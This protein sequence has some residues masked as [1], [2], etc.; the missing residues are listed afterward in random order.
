MI[1]IPSGGESPG[2]LELMKTSVHIAKSYADQELHVHQ[3]SS[4]RE[5][6][7]MFSANYG[8]AK[9]KAKNADALRQ[10]MPVLDEGDLPEIKRLLMLLDDQAEMFC[11][12]L[13]C[14][15][16]DLIPVQRQIYFDKSMNGIAENGVTETIG[17]LRTRHVFTSKEGKI[18]DGHHGWLSGMIIH[19]FEVQMLQFR[20][21]K[22]LAEVLPF[23]KKFSASQGRVPNA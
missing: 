20:I 21:F 8:T 18:L 15:P 13:L 12:K 7:P 2:E 14:R 1:I 22:P 9:R 19:P 3:Q 16:G 6:L 17:W 10:N 4:Q 11:D 23:L 5:E